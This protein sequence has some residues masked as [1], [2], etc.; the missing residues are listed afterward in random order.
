MFLL[1]FIYLK[2]LIDIKIYKKNLIN[3]NLA[4][5]KLH[6]CTISLLNDIF[7][8]AKEILLIQCKL[9]EV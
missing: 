2:K 8:D 6:K 5:K 4:I 9:I 7:N 1:L 3:I